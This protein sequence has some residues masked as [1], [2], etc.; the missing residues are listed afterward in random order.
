MTTQKMMAIPG[1]K[2]MT[3]PSLALEDMTLD[4]IKDTINDLARQGS[5]FQY[6]IG[7][8]YNHVVSRKLAELAGYR[9]VQQY[10]SQHVKAISKSSLVN[11]GIVARSF[12]EDACT[13]YGMYRLRALVR[14]L[15]AINITAPVDPGLVFIDVPQ[16]DGKV[17]KKVFSECSVDEVESATRA[18]KAPIPVRV[19]V[20]DQARLL[21]LEDSL[22]RN[23]DGVAQVRLT[24]NNQEGQTFLTVQGV[25]MSEV[26]RLIQAL[27]QGL[28]A[29]P[30]LAAK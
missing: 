8:M 25:P 20:P 30:S 1:I 24:A 17:V 28:D 5:L 27:Q 19:P 13:K 6:Q 3:A 10:F 18:K 22:F 16:D 12:S 7:V 23:F 21:F 2:A 14:Y 4:Q 11:Y 15:E 29:Q 26:T 9:T